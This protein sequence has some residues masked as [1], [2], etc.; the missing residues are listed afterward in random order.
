MKPT[1]PFR[2]LVPGLVLACTLAVRV[3]N[4]QNFGGLFR[5]CFIYAPLGGSGSPLPPSPAP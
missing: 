1:L 3:Y 2:L 4:E 5:R